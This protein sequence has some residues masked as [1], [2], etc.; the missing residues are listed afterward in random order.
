MASRAAEIRQIVLDAIEQ[1][2]SEDQAAQAAGVSVERVYRILHLA[3]YTPPADKEDPPVRTPR[4]Q[5]PR[6]RSELRT[7][8]PST[9]QAFQ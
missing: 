4:K 3:E 2:K 6:K 1:G 7:I 9:R 5:P 8:A